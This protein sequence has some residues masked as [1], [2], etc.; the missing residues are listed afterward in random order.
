MR[1]SA[2]SPVGREDG[3]A[4][5]AVGGHGCKFPPGG[6]QQQQQEESESRHSGYFST[7]DT[8]NTLML[9]G[10]VFT[11]AIYKQT[12]SCKHE[13]LYNFGSCHCASSRRNQIMEAVRQHAMQHFGEP[14]VLFNSAV[15][16]KKNDQLLQ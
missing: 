2:A 9:V 14:H 11:L 16:K 6:Q 15:P 5:V 7:N 13:V 10:F 8:F 12:K 1:G 3:P 4:D